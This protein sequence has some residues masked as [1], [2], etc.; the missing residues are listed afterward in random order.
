M[1]YGVTPLILKGRHH[2]LLFE[3]NMR[4]RLNLLKSDTGDNVYQKQDTKKLSKHASSKVRMFIMGQSVMVKDN[5]GE[6]T[7]TV[8]SN[9]GYLTIK[10]K[11]VW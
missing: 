7:A 3:R 5:W 6:N 11:G 4:T 1:T 2:K 10:S 8:L 9:L